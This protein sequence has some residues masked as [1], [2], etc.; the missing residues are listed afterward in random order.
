MDHEVRHV[1]LLP[2]IVLDR[3]AHE[4][5]SHHQNLLHAKKFDREFRFVARWTENP[6]PPAAAEADQ[7]SSEGGG[8][9]PPAGDGAT[10]RPQANCKS[11]NPPGA[12]V[13]VKK[14][15]IR[16]PKFP[17]GGCDEIPDS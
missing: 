12:R 14:S 16:N 9:E 15:E 4:S 7:A 1:F 13:F 17:G 5:E 6:N 10:R 11:E 2:F 3:L 8:Y